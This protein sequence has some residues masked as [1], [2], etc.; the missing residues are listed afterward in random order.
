MQITKKPFGAINGAPVD[1]FTLTNHNGLKAEII[2][3]GGIIVSLYTPDRN[4][5]MADIT[6]G[7]DDLGSYLE[8][9]PYFGAIVGRYANR[10]EGACFTLNGITYN[11]NRNE[12]DN[13]LHGGLRGFDKV[14]WDAQIIGEPDHQSLQLRYKSPDGEERYP[15]NLAVTVVYSLNED[16]ALVIEY[17]A[18]SDKDTVVNL[19]N[20]AYFNLSG[21]D[22]GDVL[23]H[24]LMIRARRFTVIDEACVP[25]GE[26]RDVSGTPMDFRRMKTV[27]IG[28]MNDM[29]DEQMKF[30][31]GYDHN[32]VLDTSGKTPEKAAEL[33]EPRSGRLME[34]YTTKPG[35]QFY[36]GNHLVSAGLG[37][38]GTAY[39]NW[40]GLCLETQYFPNSM[41]HAHFPS[42]ILKAGEIYRHVTIYRFCTSK[43]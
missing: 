10:L 36:S 38:G 6:L 20:H 1:L 28:L 26:I 3:Y 39:K 18:V 23:D 35:I 13:Q 17:T 12:G 42:P 2:N 32:Y 7:Y 21:H 31:A 33:Y 43:R 16:N 27:G 34:V 4:G 41:R 5:A 25:T 15:G 14:I 40:S 11:L 19:T 30:G 29:D 37:K 8:R 9:S 22:S 24:Q